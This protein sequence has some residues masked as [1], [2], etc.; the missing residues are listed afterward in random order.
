MAGGTVKDRLD[1]R[2][3]PFERR[4]ELLHPP[5]DHFG[6]GRLRNQLAVE[7]GDLA[8]ELLV[9]I[10]LVGELT[11]KPFGFAALIA[12]PLLQLAGFDLKALD[13][14]AQ[15]LGLRAQCHQLDA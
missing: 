3:W 9:A 10:T 5:A 1:R 6:F 11:R 13:L 14:P 15:G 12:Q 8:A 2:A 4:R 7:F